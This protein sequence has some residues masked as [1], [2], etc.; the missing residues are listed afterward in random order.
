MGILQESMTLAGGVSIPR[1]GFGTWQIPEGD[2][3]YDAVSRALEAGYRHIDT[4]LAYGN[5]KSV[6]RAVRNAGLARN[7]V[8]ITSKLPAEEKSAGA[9]LR[10]FEVTMDNLGLETLDLYLIHA[11]WPWNDVGADCTKENIALWQEMEEIQQSGR[12]RAVG[13]S[14]FDIKDLKAILETGTMKP[15]AN[16]ICYYIGH[17]QE[18]ITGF[19]REEGILVEGYSPL[20]T[21]RILGNP[22]VTAIAER[23][24]VSLPQVCIRYVLQKNVLPLPKAVH[25]AYIRQNAAVDFVLSDE[26]MAFLDGLTDTVR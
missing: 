12:C 16:Q 9:A 22:Q 13:V 21:G 19:C 10:C 4:A 7:E 11:P 25:E 1:L 14:N 18:A 20:A 6:G 8:F 2:A 24:G 17:T 3:C 23:Y 26:D 15:A 5:E